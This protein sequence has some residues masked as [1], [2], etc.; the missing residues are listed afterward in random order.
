MST[1][2]QRTIQPPLKQRKL[3]IADITWMAIEP[4]TDQQFREQIEALVSYKRTQRR[5]VSRLYLY[6]TRTVHEPA[7]FPN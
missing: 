4:M 3:L 6:R 5:G 7:N 2:R 1:D